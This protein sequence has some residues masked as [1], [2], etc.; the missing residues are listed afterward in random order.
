MPQAQ[1]AGE[2]PGLRAYMFVQAGE[3][4]KRRVV[5][6]ALGLAI[7][8]HPSK[9]HGCHPRCDRLLVQWLP[10]QASCSPSAISPPV[11]GLANGVDGSIV[12]Q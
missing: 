7:G 5:S 1:R 3:A 6:D 12:T 4:D 11:N 10:V 2:Q 9:L 8:G